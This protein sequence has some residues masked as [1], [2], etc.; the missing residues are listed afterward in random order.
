MKK[1]RRPI[2][3]TARVLVSCDYNF[4][5][6]VTHA[7][8]CLYI[9]GRS[10]LAKA[11]LEGADLHIALACSVLGIRYEDFD[12]KNKVHAAARQA[13]KPFNFGKPGGMGTAKLVLQQRKQ[14]PDTPCE[15]GPAWITVD[16]KKVRGYKGLRFCILMGGAKSC[17]SDKV[18]QWGRPGYER[19]ISP[20]C[21]QC[22]EC[23]DKLGE[24][25]MNQWGENRDYFKW[26]SDVSENGQLLE[27]WQADVLGLP[28]GSRLAPGE[29]VQHVSCIVRGGV[30]FT[31]CSNGYFQSLLAVAAKRALRQ[32]QRECVDASYVV[33]SD[34]CPGGKVSAYAGQRSPLF[35]SRVIVLQHDECLAELIEEFL[36]DGAERLSE[37]MVRCLQ[38]CCP[39]LAPACKAP[40]AAARRW[41]K[42]MDTVRH[43]KA[44]RL[45]PWSPDH[46]KKCEECAAAA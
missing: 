43:G 14:G 1:V 2:P 25:W 10:D 30:A 45:V 23:A 35:G 32:A 41:W 46:P 20:T 27:D 42:G 8:S 15:N 12:K 3:G 17:G 44:R 11:L 26:T 21:R 19:P 33:P 16:G 13:A 38:E 18:T 22:L 5:E 28:R 29:M 7:Q 4:G 24:K 31:D 9:L 40:P 37:I 34:A 6:L 39:D 36:H